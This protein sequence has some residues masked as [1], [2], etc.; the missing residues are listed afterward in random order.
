MR[1]A[2]LDLVLPRLAQRL[3]RHLRRY[4]A[5]QLDESQFSDRFEELLQQ[6]HA[7]LANRG[8]DAF[9]AG[10]AIHA[11]VIVLS[12][13]GL[14]AEAR[15]R[16]LPLEVVE[17]EA[18]LAAARDLSKTYGVGRRSTTQRLSRMVASYTL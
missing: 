13:P 3:N 10:L 5:G 7:W 11:A 6:Q 17:Y 12:A 14:E 16:S 2:L 9:D 15:E 1:R 8:V 18:V 4:R